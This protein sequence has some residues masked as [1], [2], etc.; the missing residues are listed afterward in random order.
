MNSTYL[1][2]TTDKVNHLNAALA[3]CQSGGGRWWSY[4]VS[5]RTFV[6]LIGDPT[7]EENVVVTLAA[8]DHLSGPT[9][10]SVQ[11]LIVSFTTDEDGSVFEVQDQKVNFLARSRVLAWKKNFDLLEDSQTQ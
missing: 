5:H 9:S 6:L 1:M 11:H 3:T 8:C 2:E 7:G 10:W 4:K